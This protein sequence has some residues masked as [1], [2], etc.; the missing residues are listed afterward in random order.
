[1]VKKKEANRKHGGVR[2]GAGAS[3]KH[4]EGKTGK[5]VASVPQILIDKFREKAG[6]KGLS[7]SEVI[8]GFVRKYV[9]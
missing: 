4:P 9:K 3:P 5:L 6:S 8:T 7:P 1:M 2:E